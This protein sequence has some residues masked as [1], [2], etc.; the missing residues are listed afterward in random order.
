MRGVPRDRRAISC[1]RLGRDLHVQDARRPRDNLGEVG[2]VVE[3]EAV[4]DAKPRSER[5]RQQPRPRRRPDERERLHRQLGGPRARP[6]PDHDVD[7]EVFHRRVELFL[8][9][10]THPVDFVDEQDV[11]RLQVG[12]NR[13]DVAGLLEHGTGRRADR[14]AELV[15]DDIG[16]RRLAESWRAEQQHVI[17]RLAALPRGRDRHVEIAPHTLLADV[18]VEEPRAQPGFGTGRHHPPGTR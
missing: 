10:R 14:D 5:R 9:R 8:D 15:A 2:L 3:V 17:E 1:R 13:G 11:A 7:L 12:E 18:F 4:D 6:L 16:E